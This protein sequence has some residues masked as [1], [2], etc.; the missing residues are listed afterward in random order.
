MRDRVT[1]WYKT[2]DTVRDPAT[3]REV[4][5]WLERFSSVAKVQEPTVMVR[6]AETGGQ[7]VAV[8]TR[9]VRLPVSKPA[10]Q[11]DDEIEVDE[12]LDP[13]LVGRRLRTVGGSAKTYATSRRYK[14][15]EV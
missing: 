11:S 10:I 3:G 15:E 9:E 2:G 7:L 1:V 13:L 4:P 6:E 14:V 8:S 12:S 5:V